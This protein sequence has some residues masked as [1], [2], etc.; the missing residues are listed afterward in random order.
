[1]LQDIGNGLAIL[2]IIKILQATEVRHSPPTHTHTRT[3]HLSRFGSLPFLLL[4]L[5]LTHNSDLSLRHNILEA[6]MSG[7]SVN[8]QETQHAEY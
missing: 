8:I 6:S 1:M 5:L 3:P 2:V 7:Q 4:S